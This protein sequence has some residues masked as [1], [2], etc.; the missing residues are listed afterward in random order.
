MKQEHHFSNN[1]FSIISGISSRTKQEEQKSASR[2]FFKITLPLSLRS[3][4]L[5]ETSR[6]PNHYFWGFFAL[7]LNEDKW[8][9]GHNR[10]ENDVLIRRR[11]E[12]QRRL[13]CG[14]PQGRE[15]PRTFIRWDLPAKMWETDSKRRK[16]ERVLAPN[17]KMDFVRKVSIFFF[18]LLLQLPDFVE[19]ANDIFHNQFA[20]HV[21]AG[22]DVAD[23]IATKH[24]FV[25][26][27][28]GPIMQYF[29][30]P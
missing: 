26:I 22:K 8:R 5:S 16:K 2:L 3:T 25:N 4:F 17:S 7:T 30:L 20:V 27:G 14:Q 10:K 6:T 18:I 1:R 11:T 12:E 21:P 15:R 23:R 24:G 19:P 9:T 29:F 13:E 28:Q